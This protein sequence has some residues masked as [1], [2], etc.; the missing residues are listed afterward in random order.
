[1]SG[2][3]LFEVEH[4]N[5]DA[6]ARY[7]SLVAIESQQEALLDELLLILDTK[8]ADEWLKRHHAKGLPIAGRM[9][10]GSPLVLLSGEVGCRKTELA[11]TIG[12]PLAR[13]STA[14]SCLWRRLRNIRG[15]GRVGEISP[16]SPKPSNRRSRVRAGAAGLLILDEA[17]DL[18]T[19]RG[20]CRR[21][22]KTVPGS[23][24]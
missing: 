3:H 13:S 18:A 6:E 11:T 15:W 19:A 20:E 14:R 4:P 10:G 22:T 1:M 12:S 21:T 17:D 7:K 16:G 9:L 2:L 23:T 24:C 8:R 5:K